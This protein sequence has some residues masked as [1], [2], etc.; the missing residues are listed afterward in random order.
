MP[1]GKLREFQ[2][3]TSGFN[4]A[5]GGPFNL[6]V[7]NYLAWYAPQQKIAGIGGKD[8]YF[9]IG[10]ELATIMGNIFKCCPVAA[11]IRKPA[12]PFGIRSAHKKDI[13]LDCITRWL[14][15]ICSCSLAHLFHPEV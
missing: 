15:V 6:D 10:Y 3:A 7:I 13:W 2:P 11:N 4:T 14:P 8:I 12:K 1:V 5:E 9:H